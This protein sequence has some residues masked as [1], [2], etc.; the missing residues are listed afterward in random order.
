MNPTNASPHD[1]YR[2]ILSAG[3]TGTLFLSEQLGRVCR[4]VVAEH[5]PPPARWEHVLGNFR[6]HWS[7][8]EK[9][10]LRYLAR[11]RLRRCRRMS[12]GQTYVEINPLLCSCCDLLPRLGFRLHVVHMVREPRSWA[13]SILKFK[14]SGI[15]KHVIEAI[16]YAIPYPA[17]R[18]PQWRQ[19]SPAEKALWR[20]RYCNET[21]WQFRQEYATYTLIR[22]EDLFSPEAERR[23]ATLRRMLDGLRIDAG[24]LEKFDIE[25]RF[26]AAPRGAACDEAISD[27]MVARICGSLALSFGYGVAPQAIR[28]SP[29]AMV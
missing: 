29:P 8:S 26:N 13:A 7:L 12:P 24:D 22:Y 6:R 18:P 2:C 27:D 21:I 10:L 14:A 9:Y 19:I 15:W 1:D 5:E 3:R 25:T 23:T 17:P 20:W 4:H 28:E 11:N 16:P